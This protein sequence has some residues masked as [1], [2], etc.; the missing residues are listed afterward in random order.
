MAK[1]NIVKLRALVEM[2]SK[3]IKIYRREFQTA[4]RII[5]KRDAEIEALRNELEKQKQEWWLQQDQDEQWLREH[6]N[7]TQETEL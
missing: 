2:K 5:R 4:L 7:E 6:I 3:L 1:D